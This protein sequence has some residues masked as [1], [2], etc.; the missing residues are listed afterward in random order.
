MANSQ[1]QYSEE[2]LEAILR[3]SDSNLSK[4]DALS[5]ISYKDKSSEDDMPT[6]DHYK[7]NKNVTNS[8]GIYNT[9]NSHKNSEVYESR[10]LIESSTNHKE[11]E[12]SL[13]DEL[14]AVDDIL[15]ETDSDSVSNV[16]YYNKQN[17]KDE[18]MSEIPTNPLD[19]IEYKMDYNYCNTN[20]FISQIDKEID[21]E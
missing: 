2:Q 7:D 21:L 8:G 11:E 18:N 3:E 1:F 4:E 6:D 19:L 5:D 9:P 10:K 14:R 16:D 13:A 17:T 15:S 20:E 12:L